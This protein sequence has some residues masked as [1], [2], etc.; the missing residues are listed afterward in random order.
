MSKPTKPSLKRS[1]CWK[2]FEPVSSKEAKCNLCPTTLNT[3]N[4]ATTSLNRHLLKRHFIQYQEEKKRRE[5]QDITP[6]YTTGTEPLIDIN[7]D[8]EDTFAQPKTQPPSTSASSQA[9]KPTATS[10]SIQPTINSAMES[11]TPYGDKHPRKLQ[12]DRKVLDLIVVD[13]QPLSVVEDKAFRSLLY[14]VDKRYTMIARRTLRDVLLPK[15]YKEKKTAL[16]HELAAV[17]SVGITTDQWT[18]RATE[19][20]TTV[21]CHYVKPDWTLA[22]PVLATQSTGKRH[23]GENMA[24]ELKD[25]FKDFGIEEKVTSIVTDNAKNAKKAVRITKKDTHFESNCQPRAGGSNQ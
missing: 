23:N 16:F 22:S 19:G 5:P 25:I 14:T 17:D 6:Q 24:E 12:I 1:V 15:V 4:G 9:S 3:G 11:Q 8:D 7:E 2:F 21:T 18:S 20:Y 13:L 10:S